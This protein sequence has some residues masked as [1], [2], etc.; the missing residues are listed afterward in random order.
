MNQK[1]RMDLYHTIGMD[2]DG[3]ESSQISAVSDS[4]SD[5]IGS[6]RRVT[7]SNE[8]PEIIIS[9]ILESNLSPSSSLYGILWPVILQNAP[10]SLH[11]PLREVCYF[12]KQELERYEMLFDSA[13]TKTYYKS[14]HMSDYNRPCRLEIARDSLWWAWKAYTDGFLTRSDFEAFCRQGDMDPSHFVVCD[15]SRSSEKYSLLSPTKDIVIHF[16][17]NPL[18]DSSPPIEVS[19]AYF[20]VMGVRE[21]AKKMY[22]WYERHGFYIDLMMGVPYCKGQIHW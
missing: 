3:D 5:S 8:T 11:S 7:S 15:Y 1:D 18:V 4:I 19:V 2:E 10:L 14:I 17:T 12:F 6:E 13:E 21:K 22:R 9:S 16:W 20:Y